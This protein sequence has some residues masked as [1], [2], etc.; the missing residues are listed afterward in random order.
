MTAKLRADMRK[1]RCELYRS[2][3]RKGRRAPK[4]IIGLSPSRIAALFKD[5]S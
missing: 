5:Q 2:M 3:L 4:W 1:K